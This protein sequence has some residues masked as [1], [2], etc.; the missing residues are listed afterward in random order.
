MYSLPVCCS[1]AGAAL[2]QEDVH[3][4]PSAAIGGMDRAKFAHSRMFVT[5]DDGSTFGAC[6]IHCLAIDLAVHIDKTPATIQVGD[7]ASN[8]SMRSRPSG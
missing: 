1:V 5:Y 2:A 3:K 4:S 7:Y 6:S 8:S